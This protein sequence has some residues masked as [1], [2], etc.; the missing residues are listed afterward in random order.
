MEVGTLVTLATRVILSEGDTA[1]ECPIELRFL[2]LIGQLSGVVF[3]IK[4]IRFDHRFDFGPENG[5]HAHK[6]VGY[7]NAEDA[8]INLHRELFLRA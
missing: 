1:N 6:T 8:L 2:C 4:K 3:I 7:R 5:T